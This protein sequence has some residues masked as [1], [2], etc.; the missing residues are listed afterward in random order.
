MQQ[1]HVPDCPPLGPSICSAKMALNVI[2]FA[3]CPPNHNLYVIAP[4]YYGVDERIELWGLQ[5]PHTSVRPALAEGLTEEQ[6]LA[7]G[8]RG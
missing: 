7:A 5:I 8:K 3:P 6:A 1:G 4:R 2:L